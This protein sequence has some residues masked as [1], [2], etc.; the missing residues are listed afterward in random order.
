MYFVL[1][2]KIKTLSITS[3]YFSHDLCDNLYFSTPENG[4]VAVFIILRFTPFHTVTILGNPD[5]LVNRLLVCVI[6]GI[7]SYH[8]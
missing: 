5:R 6:F 8:R 4:I 1:E 2:R 7:D 3:W